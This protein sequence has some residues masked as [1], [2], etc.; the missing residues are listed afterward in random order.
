[1][2]APVAKTLKVVELPGLPP[3]G[4]LTD[5]VNA[6][7]T[8]EQIRE[9]YRNAQPWTPEWEFAIN[10]PDENEKYVRTIEEEIEAAGGPTAFWD[11]AK[12]TGL[13]TPFRKLNSVLGGGMRPGEVYV[14]G[15]NPYVFHGTRGSPVDDHLNG[16]TEACERAGL[17]GLLF[18]DL[19]RSAV[20]NMKRAGIQDVVA[21]KIS[22]HKTRSI[23]EQYCGRVGCVRS[24][25]KARNLLRSTQGR[26]GSEAEEGE[27]RATRTATLR[28]ETVCGNLK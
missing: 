22:G 24:C 28:V 5:F 26:P 2:L 4:D 20:R 23:F 3:K 21:M 9:Q 11:L 6:G 25:R 12:F 10:L 19:R 16:W 27:V 8:V 18:H 17:P 7:G 14:I 13:P 1:L 15:A